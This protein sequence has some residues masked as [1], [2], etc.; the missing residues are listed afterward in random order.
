MQAYLGILS[1]RLG[2]LSVERI[3]LALHQH[4]R[5]HQVLEALDPSGIACF[6]VVLEG[7]PLVIHI[8]VYYA[9]NIMLQVIHT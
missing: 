8:L 6:V 9:R 1:I 4:V 5:K 2:F 3:H 7:L